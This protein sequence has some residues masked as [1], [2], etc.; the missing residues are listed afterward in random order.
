MATGLSTNPSSKTEMKEWHT[1][2]WLDRSGEPRCSSVIMPVSSESDDSTST[3]VNQGSL[4]G[5]SERKPEEF[6]PLMVECDVSGFPPKGD[7]VFFAVPFR[8]YKSPVPNA[9]GLILLCAIHD[10]QGRPVNQLEA[11]SRNSMD[12]SNQ[13]IT[14]CPVSDIETIEIAQQFY[15]TT[16]FVP[17]SFATNPPAKPGPFGSGVGADLAVAR[18]TISKAANW[19]TNLG[20]NTFRI[21]PLATPSHW[22]VSVRV[23]MDQMSSRTNAEAHWNGIPDSIMLLRF[24]IGRACEESNLTPAFIGKLLKDPWA[25]SVLKITAESHLSGI[26]MAKRLQ[27]GHES[28]MRATAPTET[29]RNAAEVEAY[30]WEQ[31]GPAPVYVVPAGEQHKLSILVDNRIPSSANPYVAIA[32]WVGSWQA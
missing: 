21:S 6:K 29:A 16:K 20:F 7:A 8:V 15:V 24:L 1:Y 30:V 12:F 25:P 27:H 9:P 11:N 4:R 5:L 14:T 17:I 22:T 23:T 32:Q 18:A 3:S 13:K 2:V 26:E 28:L 19:L 10:E 31:N